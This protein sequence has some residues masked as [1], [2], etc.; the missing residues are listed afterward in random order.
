M[1]EEFYYN[2]FLKHKL[3]RH[4]SL[5][6]SKGE[7]RNKLGKSNKLFFSGNLKLLFIRLV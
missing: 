4:C 6:L 2:S 7:K 5:T 3:L 1:T